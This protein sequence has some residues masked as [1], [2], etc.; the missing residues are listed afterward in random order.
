MAWRYVGLP[1]TKNTPGPFYYLNQRHRIAH[2]LRDSNLKRR[3]NPA[4]Q[5]YKEPNVSSEPDKLNKKTVTRK[6]STRKQSNSHSHP[7]S[8]SY[9]S[10]ERPVVEYFNTKYINNFTATS[11]R[12]SRRD[13]RYYIDVFV[14]TA[15]ELNE[16]A[17]GKYYLQN[18]NLLPVVPPGFPFTKG[19]ISANGTYFTGEQNETLA[20]GY[21]DIE[22]KTTK[23]KSSV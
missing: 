22:V 15:A 2:A 5:E 3:S 20:Y 9:I 4:L 21:I 1:P 13:P 19:R 8:F 17:S 7:V 14:D 11:R 18:I 12:I 23:I 6:Q 16:R 10:A